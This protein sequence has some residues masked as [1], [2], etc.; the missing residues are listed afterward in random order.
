MKQKDQKD[1]A[2]VKIY[3]ITNWL[4]KNYNTQIYLYLKKYRQSGNEIWSVNR[5]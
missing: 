1:Q 2:N 5:V 4:T 3:D